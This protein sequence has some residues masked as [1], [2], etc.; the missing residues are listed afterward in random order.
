M[1]ARCRAAFLLFFLPLLLLPAGCRSN[2]SGKLEGELR[3]R[4]QMYREALEEQRRMEA[5]NIALRNEVEA[6]RQKGKTI[7]E[8]PVSSFGVKRIVLGRATGGVDQD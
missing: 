5:N 8:Q 4:E 6:L 3:T 2:K 7:P 1:Q